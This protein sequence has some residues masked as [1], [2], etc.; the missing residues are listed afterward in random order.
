MKHMYDCVGFVLSRQKSIINN[1][2]VLVNNEWHPVKFIT[3][4]SQLWGNFIML[5]L[6]L[7]LFMQK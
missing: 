5:E 7:L 4:V 6:H 3:A 2:D 1:E